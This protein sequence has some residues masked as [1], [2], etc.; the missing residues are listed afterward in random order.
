MN[1][2]AF[3]ICS[4][5]YLA[6]AATLGESYLEY[7]PESRFFIGLADE[8]NDDLIEMLPRGIEVI[9]AK[10]LPLDINKLTAKYT[11]VEFNTCIKPSLFR[12]IFNMQ[13]DVGAVIFFDPDI[14][15]YRR[16]DEILDLLRSKNIILTP[17]TLS[18]L[19]VDELQPRESLFLNYGM[20]N[21][22]FLALARE[23]LNFFLLDWWEERLMKVGYNRP[24][25]GLFTDQL[26]ANYFPVYFDNCAVLKSVAFN[27]APWNL[28]ERKV[29]SK[30]EDSV[31]LSSG[32]MLAFYHFSSYDFKE[33]DRLAKYYPRFSFSSE[34]VLKD[35]YDNYRKRLLR[36]HIEEF[37][38]IPYAYVKALPTKKISLVNKVKKR[39]KAYIHHHSK[40]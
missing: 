19:P 13:T 26:W 10:N 7:H 35:L 33:P 37:S 22:G 17:H 9:P 15:I 16:L 6:Q 31:Q 1:Y 11:I 38:Q 8:P 28:H 39:V 27:M 3:T 30:Q 4:N 23:V 24:A 20:F 14:V 12:Y 40:P 21:L 34:P 5:N 18:P 32:E 2:S 36:N 25:D 29:I